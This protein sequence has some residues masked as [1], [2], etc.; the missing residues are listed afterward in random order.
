MRGAYQ[1]LSNFRGSCLY[2]DILHNR[3]MTNDTA[4]SRVRA[5]RYECIRICE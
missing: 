1:P 5:I 3:H 4:D 2:C